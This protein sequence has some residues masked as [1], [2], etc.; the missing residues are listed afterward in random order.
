VLEPREAILAHLRVVLLRHASQ[1]LG[2]QE[3]QD[4]LDRLEESAPALVR[5][6]T[7]KPLP[8]ERLVALLKIL[9]E[10]RVSVRD[11]RRVLESAIAHAAE[12]DPYALAEHVRAD[13]KRGLTAAL[14]RGGDRIGVLLVAPEVEDVL[15]EAIR[16]LGDGP[17]MLVDPETAEAVIRSAREAVAALPA[18]AG[19]P[20]VLTQP[21]IR[22]HL[23]RLL[24]LD[25]P[26]VRVVSYRELDPATRIDVLGRI[27]VRRPPAASEPRASPRG[28]DSGG[29]A[30]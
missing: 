9:A 24:D 18:D 5:S 28:G 16:D 30:P 6:A 1:F 4:L 2:H 11:L 15:R 3:V 26:D 13:L 23:W 19:P 21:E 29:P 10:E 17:R 20:V 25:V 14:A 7:P 22:R 12:K 27:A 8:L